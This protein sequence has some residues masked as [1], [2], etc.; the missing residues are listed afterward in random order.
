MKFLSKFIAFFVILFFVACGYL[1]VSQ[2][3]NN[4]FNEK[5]YLYVKIDEKDPENS[6]FIIDSMREIISQKFKKTL[7]NKEE[8]DDSIFVD[9]KNLSFI[10]IVYDKNGYIIAYKVKLV[11]NFDILYKNGSKDNFTASGS[12][13][14]SLDP[15]SIISDTIRTQ[16]MQY[17]S[18]EAFDEFIAYLAIKGKNKL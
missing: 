2:I 4:I 11:L 6:I 17:A 14:F 18:S 13:D 3:T 5:I 9:I 7:V 8:A 1:P 12:Y 15:N 10:P 16:A